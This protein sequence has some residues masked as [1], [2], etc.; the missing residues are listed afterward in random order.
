MVKYKQI[1]YRKAI[2]EL[3]DKYRNPEDVYDER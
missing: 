3:T 1:N 2:S